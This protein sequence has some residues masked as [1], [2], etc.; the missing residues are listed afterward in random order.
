M[1][2]V[3]R[4]EEAIVNHERSRKQ[5]EHVEQCGKGKQKAVVHASRWLR[6]SPPPGPSKSPVFELARAWVSPPHLDDDNDNRSIATTESHRRPSQ[7]VQTFT[8]QTEINQPTRPRAAEP[9]DQPP[10]PTSQHIWNSKLM[11]MTEKARYWGDRW[12]REF[13]EHE[14]TKT[15]QGHTFEN[16]RRSEGER[17]RLEKNYSLAVKRANEHDEARQR[18]VQ[19][20]TT[21]Y[22]QVQS[23]QKSIEALQQQFRNFEERTNAEYGQLRNRHQELQ[24]E[25]QETKKEHQEMKKDAER[26]REL[27]NGYRDEVQELRHKYQQLQS[28][29]GPSQPDTQPYEDEIQRLQAENKSLRDQIN[30]LEAQN[31][32]LHDQIHHLHT[33]LDPI[34]TQLE[35][36]QTSVRSLTRANR[37]TENRYSHQAAELENVRRDY[38]HEHRLRRR[39]DAESKRAGDDLERLRRAYGR[40]STKRRRQ[41]RNDNGFSHFVETLFCF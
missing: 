41:R 10:P 31:Q 32:P 5:L 40:T 24:A 11:E 26:L 18:A 27:R 34:R 36:L 33:Q 15:H 28:Q 9:T 21:F 8:V 37:D 7:L 14:A 13:D 4:A 19:T 29:P 30:V 38:E 35:Q 1:A 22:S 16:L 6:R 23:L 39:A 25:H 3:K 17:A 20:A 12:Q 2:H